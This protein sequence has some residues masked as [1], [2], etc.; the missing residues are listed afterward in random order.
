MVCRNRPMT[1]EKDYQTWKEAFGNGFSWLSQM[2]P[3][4]A[5][6]KSGW[7]PGPLGSFAV[8]LVG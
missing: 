6:L 5:D 4:P 7:H 3:V 1:G 8:T 2:L